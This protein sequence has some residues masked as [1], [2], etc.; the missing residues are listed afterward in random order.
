M[1]MRIAMPVAQLRLTYFLQAHILAC[2]RPPQH[3]LI[4]AR[5]SHHRRIFHVDCGHPLISA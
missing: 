4:Y 2:E 5:Q 1:H 3:L